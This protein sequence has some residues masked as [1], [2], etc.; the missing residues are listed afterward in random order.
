MDL[1][2]RV[3]RKFPATSA[4]PFYKMFN[5]QTRRKSMVFNGINVLSHAAQAK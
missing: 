3:S 2:L 1:W 4:S 5:L